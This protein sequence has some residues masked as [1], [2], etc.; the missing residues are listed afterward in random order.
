[1]SE[2]RAKKQT[3]RIHFELCMAAMDAAE[4]ASLVPRSQ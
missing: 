3:L 4:V 2:V 1:M